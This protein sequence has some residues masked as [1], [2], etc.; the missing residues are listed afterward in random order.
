MDLPQNILKGAITMDQSYSNTYE[1]SRKLGKHLSLDERGVIQILHRQGMSL[2]GI[3]AEVGCAHT[4]VMYEL[5]RGTPQHSGHRGRPPIYVAKRGQTAYNEHRKHCRKPYKLDDDLF[6][7]FIQWM[8]KQVREK[9]WSLDVCVGYAKL[10]QLF[11]MDQMVC[12]KT[13][14]NMLWAVFFVK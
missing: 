9:H 2:R 11:P 3:A 6:E 13:L 1:N 7:P 8:V 10:H 4:T 12:T 5:R 14:Y